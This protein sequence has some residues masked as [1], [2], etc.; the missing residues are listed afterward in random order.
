MKHLLF[1]LLI[2]CS[3]FSSAQTFQ[4]AQGESAVDFIKKN[5]PHGLTFTSALAGQVIAADWNAVPS[6]FG[7]YLHTYKLPGDDEEYEDVIGYVYRQTGNNT[8]ERILIDT[9]ENEGGT[10]VIT[11]V[12]FANADKDTARELVILIRRGAH[13]H[14]IDGQLYE[15][16]IYDNI[17]PGQHPAKLSYLK[18]ISQK[19]SGGFDGYQ[20]G[21]NVHSKYKTAREVRAG[22]K[23]L[24]Y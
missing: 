8:Y 24:G 13:H 21:E 15:T 18:N 9:F 19:V 5:V 17:L 10:A 3:L 14:D 2:L 4:K 12:F 6:I 7:F 23:L 20:E 1:C 11:A 16:R 22:L